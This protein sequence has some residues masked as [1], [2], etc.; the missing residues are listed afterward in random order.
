[1][2]ILKKFTSIRLELPIIISKVLHFDLPVFV[3]IDIDYLQRPTSRSK[4]NT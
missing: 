4:C 3:Y 2:I 1:M